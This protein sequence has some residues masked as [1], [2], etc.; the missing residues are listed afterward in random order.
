MP[1]QLVFDIH[2]HSNGGRTLSWL[3]VH[4]PQPRG[5]V[6]MPPLIG[7]SGLRQVY[8]FRRL[9]RRGLDG[10]SFSYR[11]HGASSGRFS[12]QTTLDD[13]VALLMTAMRVARFKKVPLY[14]LAA[15]YGAIPL[16]YAAHRTAEPF[17]RLMLI[18][19]ISAIKPGAAIRTFALYYRRLW[20]NQRYIPQISRSLAE[21]LDMLFPQVVK[22]RRRFGDLHR[23]RTRLLTTV[24]QA[25]S[26][27]PLANTYLGR[28]PMACVYAVNDPFIKMLS[29]ESS[30]AY[31]SD[32]R[33]ICPDVRF[34][35]L[36]SDHF[37]SDTAAQNSALAFLAS[38]LAI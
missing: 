23:S 1:L 30:I 15:C 25:F 34:L 11:G 32:I 19:P 5:V 14:G 38:F 17:Q 36:A 4:T 2:S 7:G 28:T 21:F 8:D 9:L 18:N 3:R 12:L 35:P 33:K 29:P 26:L 10:I 22:N 6:F 20:K 31:E 37:M 16:L 24:T 13:T 27:H